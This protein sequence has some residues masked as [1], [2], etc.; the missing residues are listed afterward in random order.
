MNEP[1][2]SSIS[3]VVHAELREGVRL[4]CQHH[5]G[6]LS[7]VPLA[8]NLALDWE[9]PFS[10][11]S[12]SEVKGCVLD[13][14]HVVVERGGLKFKPVEVEFNEVHLAQSKGGSSLSLLNCEFVRAFVVGANI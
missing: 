8:N 7:Y 3:V 14:G 2:R 11:W 9:R 13:V 10:S 4:V 1:A 5:I 6:R 12:I